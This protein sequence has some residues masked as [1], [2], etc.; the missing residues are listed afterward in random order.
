MKVCLFKN[1][2]SVLR[3]GIIERGNVIDVQRVIDV[4]ADLCINDKL[5][6]NGIPDLISNF[7]LVKGIVKKA[8]EI[9]KDKFISLF[10]DSS[11]VLLAPVGSENKILCLGKNYRAHAKEIGDQIPKE[12]ILFGK[13]ASCVIGPGEKIIYPDFATRVDPEVEL[14]VVIGKKGRNIS[15]DVADEYI[16]GYT[17]ANDI[18]ERNMEFEDMKS[19]NPWFRSKNFDTFM[20]IGPYIVTK[21]EIASPQ[22]LEISLSV[23]GEVRQKG[24]TKD[25]IFDVYQLV[26]YIS[27]Y[28]TLSF[29]DIIST[30]TIPGI[31]PIKRGDKV[32]AKIDGIGELVNEVK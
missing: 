25:M 6:I 15:V 12:P 19:G 5:Q 2:D 4:M 17:I 22:N 20:P 1:K 7:S 11:A 10:T 29:G 3:I 27:K 24:N 14:A 32:I 16:F 21:E 8:K 23:N 28:L 13:F 9:F 30:G 26:S 18:T 31:K